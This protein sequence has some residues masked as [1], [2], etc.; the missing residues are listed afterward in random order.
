[1]LKALQPRFARLAMYRESTALAESLVAAFR[2]DGAE[3]KAAGEILREQCLALMG[4]EE[5]MCADFGFYAFL[6][7]FM[8]IKIFLFEKW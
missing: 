3:K 7:I 8:M 1:M 5:M 6:S 4:V 2:A